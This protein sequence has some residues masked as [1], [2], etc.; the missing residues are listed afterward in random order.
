H[1]FLLPA[2]DWGAVGA[3]KQAKE[4]RSEKAQ[5]LRAWARRMR[6]KPDKHQTKRLQGLAKRV[7]RLWDLTRQRM[8]ISEREIARNIDVWGADTGPVVTAVTREQVESG[9][10]DLDGPYQRLRLVMDGW[11][12]LWFWSA[13]TAPEPPERDEWWTGLESLL[14]VQG[15]AGRSGTIGLHEQAEDFAD[16]AQID[17]MEKS[18]YFMRDVMAVVADHPWLGLVRNIAQREGFFHWEL[19][20]AQIFARGGF[21]LQVGNPPWVRPDWQDKT[22]LAEFD[23]YFLLQDRIPEQTFRQRKVD[24]LGATPIENQYLDELASWAGLAESLGS[25][26]EH[27]VLDGIRPNFYMNFME[28]TW[29]NLS[30]RG[31]I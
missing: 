13:T 1:H 20:F 6:T 31:T 17:D 14:G 21:D 9:F 18:Y 25:G 24:V 22:V 28:R 8:E 10:N 30:S 4:L 16:L 2:D 15:E 29:R 3:T 12:A 26:V 23:P 5:E 7:E 19:D 27:Q 11:W